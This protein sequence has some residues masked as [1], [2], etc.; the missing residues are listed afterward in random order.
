MLAVEEEEEEEEYQHSFRWIKSMSA[1]ENE[2][3]GITV[4]PF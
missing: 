2:V 3:S 4:L 1:H